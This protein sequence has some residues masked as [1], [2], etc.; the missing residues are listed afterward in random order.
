MSTV[1]DLHVLYNGQSRCID[2]LFRVYGAG[3][4]LIDVPVRVPYYHASYVYYT[5]HYL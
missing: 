4:Y 5:A 3:G 1:L 2:V